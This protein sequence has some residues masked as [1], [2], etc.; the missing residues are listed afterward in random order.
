MSSG[1]R[2]LA[3]TMGAAATVCGV[4]AVAGVGAPAGADVPA[5]VTKAQQIV[6]QYE[7]TPTG[8][9]LKAPI[10]K[11]IPKG[12]VMTFVTDGTEEG[13][14]Q[15]SA[16]QAGAATLGWTANKIQTDGTPA[17]VQNAWAQILR[18]KPNAVIIGGYP[19]TMF[20]KAL[21]TAQKD[22][23]LTCSYDVPEKTGGGL[24]FVQNPTFANMGLPMAA[25]VVANSGNG[26]PHAVFVNLPDYPVLTSMVKP[27]ENSMKKLAPKSVTKQYVVPLASIGTN[28][29]DLLVAYLR[30]HPD[31]KNLVLS[32]DG[33]AY[34]LPAAI[35]AAHLTGINIIG[36]APTTENSQ[37]IETG[38]EQAT[39]A[40]DTAVQNYACLDAFARNWAGQPL[41]GAAG[42]PPAYLNPI[43]LVTKSNLPQG[44]LTSHLF[45]VLTNVNSVYAK[46]WNKS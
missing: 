13:A 20:N 30:A 15:Y 10:T 28:A 12:K 46:L 18:E 11:S 1:I 5:N 24:T 29:P 16:V 31:V 4:V 26:A 23:I 38:D 2:R 40:T 7:K 14:A 44:A 27:F 8:V 43:Q 41:P 35:K 6:A 34:G 45:P 39:I 36:E 21:L 25:Q 19:R 22:G 3:A 17:T 37:Y 9:S 32:F 42:G 33:L